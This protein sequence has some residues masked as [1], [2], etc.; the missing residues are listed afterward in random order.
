MFEIPF[1][2]TGASRS[3]R[4]LMKKYARVP[5]D[6]ADACLVHL[7]DELGTRRILTLDSDFRTYRWRKRHAFEFL[8]D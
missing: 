2:L 6:F 4:L 8:I 5:M 7:A 1:R 3:I